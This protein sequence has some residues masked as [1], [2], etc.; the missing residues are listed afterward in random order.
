MSRPRRLRPEE[1]ELQ[2]MGTQS[3]IQSAH[4][5]LA[6]AEW[7]DARR[8]F[9]EALEG[10]ESPEVLEGL[11]LAAWWLDDDAA[12]FDARERAYRLY[13]ARADRR[14]AGRVAMS[15]AEDAIYF[16]GQP[17]IARGWLARARELLGDHEPIPEHGW[18]QIVS[19]D[20][21]LIVDNDP[22]EALRCA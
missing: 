2:A 11:G 7:A 10:Q 8:A 9:E 17:A 14:G 5:A 20:L 3:L 12:V 18:L 6:R 4:E 1:P 16:R 21:A 15:L 22:D 13:H 19:G